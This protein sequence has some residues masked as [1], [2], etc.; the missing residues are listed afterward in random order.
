MITALNRPHEL[1]LHVRGGINNGLSKED[2][3][4]VFC[5]LQLT[6]ASLQQLIASASLRKFKEM[7]S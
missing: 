6:V 7:S 3:Q 2:F 1:K 5:R 4:E